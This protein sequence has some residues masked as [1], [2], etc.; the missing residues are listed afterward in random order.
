MTKKDDFIWM[1][2]WAPQRAYCMGNEKYSYFLT[3]DCNRDVEL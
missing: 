1:G 3:K 2:P